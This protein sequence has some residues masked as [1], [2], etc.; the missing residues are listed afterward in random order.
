MPQEETPKTATVSERKFN[1]TATLTVEVPK[2][3]EDGKRHA[4]A[5][6]KRYFRDRHGTKP[7]EVIAEKDA[8]LGTFSDHE[9][10]DVMVADH[11][12][13]SFVNAEDYEI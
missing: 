9:E 10:W 12:S 4:K 2:D 11:S 5:F 8:V 6:A 3:V 7:T 1:G 13:G